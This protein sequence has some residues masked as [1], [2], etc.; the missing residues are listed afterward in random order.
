MDADFALGKRSG[1]V[2]QIHASPT[3]YTINAA[4]EVY[5][6]TGRRNFYS[7]ESGVIHENWGPEPATAAS[8]E[9]R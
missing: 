8:A 5:N 7:D 3:G 6:G 4:P 9:F 1:Y 2:F